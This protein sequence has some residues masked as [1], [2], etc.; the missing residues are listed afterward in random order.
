MRASLLFNVVG[1]ALA[2]F[3]FALVLTMLGPQVQ[4]G[5]IAD[6]WPVP[7]ELHAKGNRLDAANP[8]AHRWPQQE[9]RLPRLDVML[10]PGDALN[11]RAEAPSNIGTGNAHAA[12][13]HHERAHNGH[14]HWHHREPHRRAMPHAQSANRL[15]GIAASVQH[16]GRNLRG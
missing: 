7:V 10:F 4:G 15:T 8:I 13:H 16:V 14:R 5:T 11:V 6:R 9:V 2:G 12:P 3:L 1:S